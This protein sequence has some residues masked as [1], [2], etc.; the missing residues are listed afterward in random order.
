MLKTIGSQSWNWWGGLFQDD[1]KNSYSFGL[2]DL[3]YDASIE[4]SINWVID[5]NWKQLDDENTKWRRLNQYKL[6]G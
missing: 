5:I 4:L 2:F 3:K 1:I 6:C